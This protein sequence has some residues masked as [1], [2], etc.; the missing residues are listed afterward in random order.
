VQTGQQGS[1]VFVVQPEMKVDL[2]PVVI[3]ESIDNQTVVTSG[4]R[5]GE[6]V[7]TDGQLRLIPGAKVTIKS[8]LTTSGA[9]S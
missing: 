5:P 8:G 9:T 6:T 3:G 1:F 7:V 2:R 4:L